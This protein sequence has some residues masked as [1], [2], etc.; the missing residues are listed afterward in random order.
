MLHPWCLL[1]WL[2]KWRPDSAL[3]KLL[4]GPYGSFSSASFN[5]GPIHTSPSLWA[6]LTTSGHQSVS[7][8]ENGTYTTLKAFK[9]NKLQR[10]EKFQGHQETT[11]QPVKLQGQRDKRGSPDA[12]GIRGDTCWALEPWSRCS[13]CQGCHQS[14]EKRG[15]NVLM[16]P[17]PHAPT[18]MSVPHPG[19]TR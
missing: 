7:S 19:Q 4:P 13:C 15:R 12:V 10:I 9:E 18:T 2:L 11:G 3:K 17:S 8:Q 16:P 5:P 14:R 6:L 1:A